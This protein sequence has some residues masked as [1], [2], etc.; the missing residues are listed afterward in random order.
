MPVG[1]AADPTGARV[2]DNARVFDRAEV[3]GDAR[4]FGDARVLGRARANVG[5]VNSGSW[6]SGDVWATIKSR[7]NLAIELQADLEESARRL[8]S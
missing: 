8:V 6:S 7:Q 4:V 2:Y 5:N 3:Y 1:D